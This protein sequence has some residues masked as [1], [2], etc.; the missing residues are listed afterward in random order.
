VSIAKDEDVIGFNEKDWD[1]LVENIWSSDSSLDDYL[2]S[3]KVY[4]HLVNI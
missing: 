1:E 2:V 4:T 3:G